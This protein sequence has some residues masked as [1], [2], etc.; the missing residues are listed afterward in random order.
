MSPSPDSTTP[1]T[2]DVV[3]WSEM[4]AAQG[5]DGSGPEASAAPGQD[6]AAGEGA[7]AASE[8]AGESAVGGV[9]GGGSPGVGMAGRSA[10]GAV[11]GEG[12][13]G[14]RMATQAE[15]AAVAGQG[16]SGM[17]DVG[18]RLGAVGVGVPAVRSGLSTAAG[19]RVSWWV[20]AA[21]FV[22]AVG[23]GVGAGALVWAGQVEHVYPP[24]YHALTPEQYD[25]CVREMTIYF[26]GQDPDP[27]MR[28]AAAEL[29][30]DERFEG[31]REETRQQAFE[32][33]KEIYKNQPDLVKLARPQA[34]PASVHVM[35]RKGDTAK[36]RKSAIE[37]TFPDAEVMIQ[38][39]CP[40]PE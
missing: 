19:R 29:R 8:M 32:R 28:A 24:G 9:A 18:T 39:W 20:V 40:P 1:D 37:A 14:V 7:S 15:T 2:S 4:A 12:S 23:V 5:Q 38:D 10:V 17:G 36:D 35:V 11:A 27:Q 34:M 30:D 31:V 26:D 3:P 25:K 22:V 6:I 21:A 13:P 16:S 33:F